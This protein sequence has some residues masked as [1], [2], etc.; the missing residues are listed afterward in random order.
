[1]KIPTA[2]KHGAYSGMTV[3]PGEDPAAFRKLREGLCVEFR[4]AGPLE[5]DIVE[6]IV[7][8]TRRK[9]NLLT[10]G[11]AAKARSLRASIEAKYDFRSPMPLLVP[12]PRTP[13]QIKVDHLAEEREVQSVLGDV[14]LELAELGDIV[15]F[16]RLLQD[17]S[18][19]DRLDG[20]IERCVKRLLMVRGVKSLA[21]SDLH[22]SSALPKVL[23]VRKESKTRRT[24]K[25][26]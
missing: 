25:A 8:L 20:M 4:P 24:T 1:M 10:Y 26:N 6:T 5:E 15:S 2:L 22:A 18:L 16:D 17:L 14:A 19:I 9:Q 23:P 13:E 12:D 11:M 21:Q 3:L 7:R